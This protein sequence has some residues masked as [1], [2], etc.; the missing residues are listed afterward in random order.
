VAGRA[1]VA[2][3]LVNTGRPF[4]ASIA[5]TLV[6]RLGKKIRTV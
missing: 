4:P 2:L 5:R 1:Q 3:S 6:R